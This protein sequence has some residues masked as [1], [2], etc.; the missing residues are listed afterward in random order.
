[1]SVEV[2]I[3][4]CNLVIPDV[5]GDRDSCHVRNCTRELGH[6]CHLQDVCITFFW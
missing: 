5:T 6:I 2:R 3:L 4:F 1:M